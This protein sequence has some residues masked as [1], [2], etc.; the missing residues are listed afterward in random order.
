MKSPDFERII[1]DPSISEE[2][3][4]VKGDGTQIFKSRAPVELPSLNPE[5]PIEEIKDPES[6]ILE[7]AEEWAKSHANISP[8]RSHEGETYEEVGQLVN[9]PKVQDNDVKFEKNT[10]VSLKEAHF[11]AVVE[12]LEP[13]I[14]LF[15]LA[16]RTALCP[17]CDVGDNV[18]EEVH[19][20]VVE[21]SECGHGVHKHCM[22]HWR[23]QGTCPLCKQIWR[24]ASYSKC[25]Y[26]PSTLEV[27]F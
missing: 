14:C 4:G 8:L 1:I 13:E 26:D 3:L 22:D 18:A 20:C 6:K 16:D 5:G 27:H 15:C 25:L 21:F 23:S 2:F 24:T 10:K 19:K 17:Y 9:L 7:I 12:D 11:V